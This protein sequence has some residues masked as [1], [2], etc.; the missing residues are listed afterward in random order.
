MIFF[1]LSTFLL[2]YVHFDE[3]KKVFPL[4]VGTNGVHAMMSSHFFLSA[5]K[6]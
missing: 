6:I 2:Y 3:E 5:E 4:V 1:I